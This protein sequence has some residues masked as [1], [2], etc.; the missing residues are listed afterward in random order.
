MMPGDSNGDVN[1]R[2]ARYLIAHA[3]GRCGRCR[4]HI[5]LVA[6][7]LPPGHE[8][9][10]LDDEAAEHESGEMVWVTAAGS[11]FLFYVGHLPPSVEGRLTAVSGSYRHAFSGATQGSYWANHCNA[12]GALIEDH[13]LF[14]EPEGAFLPTSAASAASIRL[15]AIDEPIEAAAAGYAFDP[16]FFESIEAG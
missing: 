13:D 4:A 15:I 9:L 3:K 5:D 10:V 12:C 16:Q 14:C 6:L 11:A 7:V 2:S 8:S 1:V